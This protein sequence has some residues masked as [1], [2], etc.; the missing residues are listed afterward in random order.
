MAGRTEGNVRRTP[1]VAIDLGLV[2]SND[3]IHFREPS[4]G[5]KTIARGKTGEWDSIALLQGHAFANVG[6]RTYMWYSHWNTAGPPQ[7][8][9]IGL[10]TLRR[11]GFGYLSRQVAESDG[12]CITTTIPASQEGYRLRVNVE[13]GE[14]PV[15]ADDRQTRGRGRATS[16]RASPA[17]TRPGSPNRTWI[18][19]VVFQLRPEPSSPRDQPFAVHPQLSDFRRYARLYTIYAEPHAQSRE[20]VCLALPRREAEDLGIGSWHR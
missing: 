14:R 9:E 1:D 3:G 11:D 17:R 5:F 20:E 15:L 18:R 6:D 10:A 19:P 12:H 8:M 2:V 16:H 7:D 13:A 4:P